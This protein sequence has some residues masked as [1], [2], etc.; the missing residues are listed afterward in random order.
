MS[1]YDSSWV[2]GS[3]RVAVPNP[4]CRYIYQSA[5]ETYDQR[6]NRH[7]EGSEHLYTLVLLSLAG[8]FPMPTS[9]VSYPSYRPSSVLFR[10]EH[11]SAS[12]LPSSVH[13]IS[14]M[15]WESILPSI[16]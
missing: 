3:E 1:I 15:V 10:L 14:Q 4:Y 7:E 2:T 12:T 8:F 13:I 16:I 5:K 6:R 9:F 11:R